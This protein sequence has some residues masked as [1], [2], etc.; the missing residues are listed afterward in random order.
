MKP[1]QRDDHNCP[2]TQLGWSIGLHPRPRADHPLPKEKPQGRNLRKVLR[3]A[4]SRI[5][6]FIMIQLR[7]L[8]F[9]KDLL[10]PRAAAPIQ[11]NGSP[12]QGKWCNCLGFGEDLVWPF[13][14]L[15]APH[16][17]WQGFR[18]TAVLRLSWQVEDECW[19][20]GNI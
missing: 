6:F 17:P 1:G 13:S 2:S 10:Q 19:E 12:I 18:K 15:G 8:S 11:S 14:L 5:L 7:L 16:I 4:Y 9:T 20:L 3:G